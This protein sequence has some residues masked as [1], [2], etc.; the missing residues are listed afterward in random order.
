MKL[1]LQSR[2]DVSAS[3]EYLGAAVVWG[4]STQ[5][6]IDALNQAQE[7]QRADIEQLNG[8]LQMV[9][10]ATHEIESSIAEIARNAGDVASAAEKSR[11]ASAES[12]QSINEP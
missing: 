7:A 2:T 6:T 1:D 5:Q 3:G 10:T 12:K 8:N 11:K 9:A 4:V